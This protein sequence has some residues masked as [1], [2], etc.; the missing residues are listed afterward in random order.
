MRVC[1][2]VCACV[3]VCV[4]ARQTHTEFT[5]VNVQGEAAVQKMKDLEAQNEVLQHEVCL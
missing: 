4:H 2:C 5:D 3:C 1:V